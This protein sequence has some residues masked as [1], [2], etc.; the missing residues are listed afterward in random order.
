MTQRKR[1]HGEQLP[2][3]GLFAERNTRRDILKA[4]GVVGAGALGAGFLSA[5]G[6]GG[7]SSPS[8][9]GSTGGGGGGEA[10]AGELNVLCWEGY[11]DPAFTKPFEKETGTKIN[12]T[13]IG[14]NDELIAKL[15]GA[16]GQYDLCTPSSDTTNLL[17]EAEQVQPIDLSKVPNAKTAFPFFLHA[18]NVNV[19]GNLYGIPMAWGFIPLIYDEEKIKTPPTSWDALWDPKYE[20]EVSVWQDISLLW[21]TGLLLGF[22]DVYNM[23]D[24]QLEQVKAKLIE[25]K[26]EIRKYWTTAGELTNLFANREVVIGMSYG[27]LTVT[28][29]REQGRKVNEVIPKEGATSWFDNWMILKTSE[30]LA[31]AEAWLNH[32][33]A[34]DTQKEIG[35]VTGYGITNTKAIPMMP[36]VYAESYHLDEPNFIAQL[37]YWKQTPRRQEYIDILNAVV[38]S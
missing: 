13:F 3:S 14:S 16:P 36:K 38:A 33:Q 26:P 29:L 27:G 22:D 32:I 31:T 25:Q 6:A 8:T 5:C 37:D 2:G 20:Q 35:T 19:G 28:Q 30:K 10:L 15:R 9:G 4:A 12:S 21:T 23:T 1:T 17:I 34:P 18:P 7:S 24:S 11:T